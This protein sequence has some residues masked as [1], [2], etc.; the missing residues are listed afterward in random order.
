MMRCKR[1]GASANDAS[2]VCPGKPGVSFVSYSH[3]FMDEDR[4]AEIQMWA[5]IRK[6]LPG[7]IVDAHLS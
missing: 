1:C 7:E 3:V 6:D 4:T 2:N 5:E